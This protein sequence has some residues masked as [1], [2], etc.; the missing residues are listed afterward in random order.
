M[1]GTRDYYVGQRFY[2]NKK[3]IAGILLIAVL[4]L[5]ACGGGDTAYE[6]Q[7]ANK[8]EKEIFAMDTIMKLTIYGQNAEKAFIEAENLITLYD[9]IFSVT[10]PNSDV[11]K[12]N[13]AKGSIVSVSEAT[14]DLVQ[15]SLKISEQTGGLFDVSIY[16]LVKLWGFTTE[17]HKVPDENGIQLAMKNVN[18]KKLNSSQK[19]KFVLERIW[20]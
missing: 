6:K 5:S 8:V 1:R 4:F 9:S 15:Q 2:G 18:Y 10:N 7:K 16:P 20:K 12:I 19:I 11:S 17:H 13:N 3:Y 14:Y